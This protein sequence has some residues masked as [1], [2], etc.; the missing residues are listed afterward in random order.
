MTLQN[1]LLLPTKTYP[2]S[3]LRYKDALGA[4]QPGVYASTDFMAVQRAAGANMSVDVGAGGAW[5]AGTDTTRQGYYELV[6]DAAVN[7]AV[8]AAHATLPRID[9]VIARIYD[10]SVTGS[11]DTPTI[12]VIAG[13]AT[14]GAT[15]DNRTGAAA[16][17]NSCLLLAD[18]LVG[19]AVSSLSNTVIRDRRPFARGAYYRLVRTANAAAGNDYGTSS[20][21]LIELDATNLK[22]RIEC[23]G[24]PI[25]V[26]LRGRAAI[27]IA[28]TI[29]YALWMD[30]AG[31]DGW[32]TEGSFGFQTGGAAELPLYAS[33]DMVPAAGSHRFS[34]AYTTTAGT[35]TTYA[36]STLP[37][38]LTIEEFVRANTANNLTTSG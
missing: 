9:Q 35:L 18:V 34:P 16:L 28:A 19:A 33:W 6:N 3:V 27:S 32:S 20:A 36:R 38:E 22:P 11:S 17:P 26:T 1:P 10:S 2:F 30:G 23:T 14:S 4:I 5:I 8:T 37:L 24:N 15:L 7:V 31:T 12:E 29:K 13:T 21:S 25:R